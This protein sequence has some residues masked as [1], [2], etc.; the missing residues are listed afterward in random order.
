MCAKLRNNNGIVQLFRFLESFLLI[1]TTTQENDKVTAADIIVASLLASLD[2][3]KL[4]C[5]RDETLTKH[6]LLDVGLFF[7]LHSKN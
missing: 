1:L 4:K 2:V 6:G 5:G 7:V 3:S